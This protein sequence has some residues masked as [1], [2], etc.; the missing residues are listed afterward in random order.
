V[1]LIA[2][3]SAVSYYAIPQLVALWI[4]DIPDYFRGHDYVRDT[5][6]DALSSIATVIVIIGGA[7]ALS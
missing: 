1:Y 5:V 4:G 3:L 6:G 7:E 2:C